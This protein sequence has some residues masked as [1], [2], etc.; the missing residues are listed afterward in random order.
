MPDLA[1]PTEAIDLFPATVVSRTGDALLRLLSEDES[2]RSWCHDGGQINQWELQGL[3]ETTDLNPP[4]VGLILDSVDDSQ[5]HPGAS[6]LRTTW[7][8]GY[9]EGVEQAR[10]TRGWLRARVVEHI[11]GLINSVVASGNGLLDEAGER[12]CEA[13]VQWRASNLSRRLAPGSPYCITPME[14][15]LRHLVHRTTRELI[16]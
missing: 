7:L 8:I 12:V 16:P 9:I 10:G 1:A 2:L 15:T 6:D 3:L 5:H 4:A 11:H 14:L 13:V